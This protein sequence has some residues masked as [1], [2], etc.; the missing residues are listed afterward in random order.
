MNLKNFEIK[1][2]IAADTLSQK[3]GVYTAR[4]GFFYK[5]GMTSETCKEKVFAAFPGTRI[6]EHGEVHKPF[7]GGASVANQS[8]FFVKFS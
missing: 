2:M 4:W 6:L 7:R 1:D 3:D 5:N 8:H